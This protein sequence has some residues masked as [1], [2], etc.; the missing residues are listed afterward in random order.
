MNTF[1][2]VVLNVLNELKIILFNGLDMIL[3]IL[4]RVLAGDLSENHIT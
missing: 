3:S 4:L 2:K 1:E